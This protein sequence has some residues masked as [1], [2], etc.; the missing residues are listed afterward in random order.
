MEYRFEPDNPFFGG[1]LVYTMAVIGFNALWNLR[2]TTEQLDEFKTVVNTTGQRP[3][4][5]VTL[6]MASEAE[7]VGLVANSVLKNPQSIAAAI[8]GSEQVPSIVYGD[9]PPTDTL[10]IDSSYRL[11][12]VPPTVMTHAAQIA[13]GSAYEAAKDLIELTYG[14]NPQRWPRLVEYFRHLRN[15]AFHRNTFNF[16]APRG[17]ASAIDPNNP[18][19]WRTSVMSDDA[20]MNSR[21]FVE[22]FLLIGD[23]PILLGDASIQLRKD[24]VFA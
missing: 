23:I 10:R 12:N 17:R 18:P 8:Q 16:I 24:G 21:R 11:M 14:R 3:P 13:T 9:L 22:D 2:R 7:G 15:A 20:S 1:I 4:L 6:E 5:V 19:S